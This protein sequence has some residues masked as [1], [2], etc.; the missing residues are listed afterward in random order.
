M[1]LTLITPA[2]GSPVTAAEVRTVCRVGAGS[3]H[4]GL[5]DLIRPAAVAAIGE[6][7]GSP[8]AP[9]G[10]RLT[11]DGFSDTIELPKG[12]VTDVTAVNYTDA[13]GATQLLDESVYWLDLVSTPQWLVRQS[14]ASWPQVQSDAI[15]TV[16]V[17]FVAG[18]DTSTLPTPLK[19]AVLGLCRF[20]HESGMENGIPD[21]VLAMIEPWR[22][23]WVFA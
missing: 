9:E 10:W 15:N 4:D 1:P 14:D 11:L 21:G 8:L 5:L 13:D 2:T 17:D 12:P 7:V 22:S 3:S 19:L 18:Y 23:Q 20:W 16:T 6:L